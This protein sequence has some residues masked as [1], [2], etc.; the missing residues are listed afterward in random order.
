MS[1]RPRRSDGRHGVKY[2]P[3]V[4]DTS[5]ARGTRRGVS[6]SGIAMCLVLAAALLAAC[7]SGPGSAPKAPA[8]AKPAGPA[9]TVT[10]AGGT[11]I[12][13][14]GK[15]QVSA[16]QG[17]LTSVT[18]TN[19]DGK[20]IEGIFTPDKTVWKP[21][22]PLGYN[23]TYTVTAQGLT[24]TG[25]SGPAKA[26]FSTITPSNQTKAYLTT[27][28]QAP[29]GDGGTFGV[30]MVVVAHFDE[31]IPDRAAAE[32]H[33]NVTTDP[34]VQGSWYW[35]DDQNAHWRPEKYWAPGT[36]VNVAAN[37]YGAQLGNGLYG[38]EDSKASFTIGPSHVSI[39]D[40]N[41]K[42]VQVF[43]NGKLIR[44]MPTSMGMGGTQVVNGKTIYFWTMPGTYTVMG[45]GNP[46]IMDSSTFGLPVNSR[47]GYKEAINWA[48][49]ISADGIYLHELQT[50]VWA[51][52]NTDTSHGCLNLNP[53]NAQWFYGFSNLGDI[54]EVHN[55]GGPALQVWDNGDWTLPWDQWL[56]GS[57]LNR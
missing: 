55:T 18:M 30:G 5:G 11:N 6:R 7:S 57:A 44:T 29:I 22:S 27:T 36:K 9:I 2:L 3:G 38:Q 42:Q 34:P 47:L 40:D 21:A 15:I 41:T 49:Q 8:P 28:S 51:Q 23:H 37:L 48:T 43:E 25:P 14:L 12:D 45:R 10:P 13:P 50:T 4:Q 19:E 53:A 17:Q 32:R 16:S 52:G 31:P 24:L 1:G 35:L 56:Q 54:V 20:Q 26:T 46:V 33:L 39:A